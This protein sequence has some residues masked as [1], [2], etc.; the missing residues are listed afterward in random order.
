MTAYFAYQQQAVEKLW[1]VA[2]SESMPQGYLPSM[3]PA[4]SE[5]EAELVAVVADC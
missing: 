1:I 3:R 5:A 2:A 4:K